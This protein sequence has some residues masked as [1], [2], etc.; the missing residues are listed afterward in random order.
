MPA[1]CAEYHLEISEE[2]VVWKLVEA[3]VA[4]NMVVE[5]VEAD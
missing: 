4:S 5:T 3:G 1:A 2:V